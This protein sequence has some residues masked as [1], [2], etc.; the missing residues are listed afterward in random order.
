MTIF[1]YFLIATLGLSSY[2]VGVRQMLK[3]KYSPSTFSRVIW[4]LLAINSF[5]GV[6]LSGGTKPSILLAGILLLGNIA[7]CFVSFWKGTRKMGKLEYFSLILLLI[8]VLIWIFF[9]TPL[10]NLLISLFA[11]FVGGLPTYKKVWLKPQSESLGFWSL[12]F[13]ASLLSVFASDVTSLSSIIFPIYFTLFD[14]S[15]FLLALR[16]KISKKA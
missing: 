9:K 14:G 10:V 6:F 12:F 7:I 3:N 4:V 16:R 13:L 11:H 5:A 2:F 15:M 1:Y 8:S